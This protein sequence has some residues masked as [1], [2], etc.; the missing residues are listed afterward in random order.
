MT[1]PRR[2]HQLAVGCY[3]SL[4][5]LLVVWQVWLAP[6]PREYLSLIVLILIGPLLLPLR[7]LLHGRR[8]TIAWS[9][10][11]ILIYFIHGIASMAEPGLVRW[12]GGL[13]IL[14]S[15]SYF[16]LTIRY[17]R[18]TGSRRHAPS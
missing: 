14:L 16:T 2:I 3:L 10:M 1:D 9:G 17:L 11:L 6:P 5:I 18:L 13:E 7:G 4:F 8:Y 15:L 12:L